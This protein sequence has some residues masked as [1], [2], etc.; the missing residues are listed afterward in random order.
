LGLFICKQ[1]I[2]AHHGEIMVDSTPGKG[3]TFFIRLPVE[4][5]A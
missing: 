5:A 4:P 2:E 1:I 3:T